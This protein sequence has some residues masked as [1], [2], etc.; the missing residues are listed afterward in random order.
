MASQEK[1]DAI[2]AG[3]AAL[4][5]GATPPATAKAEGALQ[6]RTYF[7]ALRA[8]G[9]RYFDFWTVE[10]DE[11]LAN[12]KRDEE[13][14]SAQFGTSVQDLADALGENPTD[15]EIGNAVLRLVYPGQ[16]PESIPA[17]GEHDHAYNWF[18]LEKFRFGGLFGSKLAVGLVGSVALRN[19]HQKT[20][21][22]VKRKPL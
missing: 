1:R 10:R 4:K 7:D 19:F 5:E 18:M 13:D 9:E 14:L 22:S 11:I 6:P 8:A 3:R 16:A 2:R 15:E 20:L 12:H 17:L 21:L